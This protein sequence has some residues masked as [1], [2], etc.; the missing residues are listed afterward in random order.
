VLLDLDEVDD[1]LDG[2][3]P[4]EAISSSVMATKGL[5]V[6]NFKKVQSNTCNLSCGSRRFVFVV[7]MF[8]GLRAI[9][10][11]IRKIGTKGSPPI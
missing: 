10:F 1:E 8:T 4:G 6:E 5:V 3:L 2:L 9:R 11:L 7:V